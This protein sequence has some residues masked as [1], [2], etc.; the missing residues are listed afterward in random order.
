MNLKKSQDSEKTRDVMTRRRVW[1]RDRS[2]LNPTRSLHDNDDFA[3]KLNSK[4]L[5]LDGGEQSDTMRHPWC[6]PVALGVQRPSTN[7]PGSPIAAR[8]ILYS[9]LINR[10]A[11]QSV[12]YP[13]IR[14]LYVLSSQN[15][16]SGCYVS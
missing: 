4:V 12:Y 3:L 7:H 11:E 9:V 8:L 1:S 14:P 15:E 10:V 13:K 6:L 2:N 16:S 5:M